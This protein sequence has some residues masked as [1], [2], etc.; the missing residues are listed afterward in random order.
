MLKLTGQS[1]VQYTF[2]STNPEQPIG[3][4]MGLLT[5]KVQ[6]RWPM[7]STSV[8]ALVPRQTRCSI[9]AC[10]GYTPLCYIHSIR[11]ITFIRRHRLNAGGTGWTA[12]S[13]RLLRQ[14]GAN[15]RQIGI[16]G[17][18]LA[19]CILYNLGKEQPVQFYE[20]FS[21]PTLRS[22][23]LLRRA[24]AVADISVRRPERNANRW[25]TRSD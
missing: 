16:R 11:N 1:I 4:T 9:P 24:Y 22:V 3:N 6:K 23:R 19:V 12:N 17:T 20:Y 21:R 10:V 14:W 25:Q 18:L 7:T 5:M 15:G 8:W 13:P 2:Q